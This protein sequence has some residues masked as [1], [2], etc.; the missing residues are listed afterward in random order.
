MEFR[1][2]APGGNNI[3]I[4]NQLPSRNGGLVF[5]NETLARAEF[6]KMI[7]RDYT[8]DG[9]HIWFSHYSMK[10]PTIFTGRAD[11]TVLEL[12]IQFQNRFD[13]EWDG[14]GKQELTPFQFNL[15]HTPFVNNWAKFSGGKEYYTFDIHFTKPYLSRLAPS[16]PKLDK[17]L[18]KVEKN[19]PADLVPVN[20][21]LTP[22][23]VTVV[24][25]MLNCSFSNDVAKFYIE[26]KVMELLIMALDHTAG[27]QIK[28]PIKLSPYDIE[29]LNEVKRIVLS[30]FE[31]NIS[32]LKLTRM[33]GL[34]VFKLK[35]GFKTL[36]GK[37][38]FEFQLA[39]KMEKAK[40]LLTA[41]KLP[42]VDIAYMMGYEH[43][44]NFNTA[45]RKHFGYT[46]GYLRK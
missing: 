36:F 8:G 33:V 45:F 16:F 42:V 11:I 30:D 29:M 7:F 46:P 41:T 44:S 15:S 23:M 20:Y 13:I 27:E 17:W 9:F 22:E 2:I 10:H 6:G 35:K 32:L 31:N 5:M 40:E 28:A 34:N 12:H 43:L 3:E 14:I 19:I 1:I 18:E 38:I 24:H 21:F 25:H 4:V 39:A 26:A 37:S